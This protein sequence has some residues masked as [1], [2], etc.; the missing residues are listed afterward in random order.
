MRTNDDDV[1]FAPGER[2]P[3]ETVKQPEPISL[4]QCDAE[5]GVSPG[6]MFSVS[7]LPPVC[8]RL[9]AAVE[10]GKPGDQL[11]RRLLPITGGAQRVF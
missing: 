4:E 7:Y 3:V 6:F 8:A 2:Y 10:G 11:R 1:R 9:Q 5:T